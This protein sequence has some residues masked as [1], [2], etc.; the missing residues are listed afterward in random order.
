MSLNLNLLCDLAIMILSGM[1][2]GRMAKHLRLPNVTGYL[3]AG[4]KEER[5][6]IDTR[7]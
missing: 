4:H 3:I 7:L 5:A 2:F 6:I 1:F